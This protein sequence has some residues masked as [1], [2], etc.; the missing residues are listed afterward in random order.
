L[1]KKEYNDLYDTLDDTEQNGVMMI[2]NGEFD[3]DL[4]KEIAKSL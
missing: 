3:Y 1:H 4:F 2:A